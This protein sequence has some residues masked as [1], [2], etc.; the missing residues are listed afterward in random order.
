MPSP[1][2]DEKDR[3]IVQLL[4]G[5]P[6]VPHREIARKVGLSQPAV[7]ARI[8]RLR[9]EGYLKIQVGLDADSVGLVLAKVD[10]VSLEPQALVES[11]RNCPL[12]VNA[13]FTSGRTN[14][15]LFFVGE[16]AEHLQT[17]V[18]VHLRPLP[19]VQGVEFQ[20]I[21]GSF[22]PWILPVSVT[23]DRCDR[24]VCGYSC[25]SCRYYQIDRCPGCPAT[26]HYKG[27][28][29]QTSPAPLVPSA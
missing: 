15:T 10:V 20:I 23:A 14:A 25:A 1:T 5:D 8:H 4:Q 9:N 24:T 2:P 7:S 17:I 18:D 22:H 27:R 16:S 6:D 3:E 11:F 21:T 13:L 12:L 19:S 26:I 29:W 28:F